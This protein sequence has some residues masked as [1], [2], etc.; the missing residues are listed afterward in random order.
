MRTLVFLSWALAASALFAGC[1]S[2]RRGEP[3]APPLK[4]DQTQALG[5]R[6]FM[7]HCNHCHPQG[8]GGLG[9]AL[10]NK[11]LPSPAMRVQIRNGLGAMPA[12]DEQR[13]DDA[14]LEAL[15]AYL[16]ELQTPSR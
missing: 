13:I 12:F 5:Q 4:L 8:E 2:A 3:F 14:Q 16:L 6:V 7:R 9:P 15:L 11:P 10:N 1:G